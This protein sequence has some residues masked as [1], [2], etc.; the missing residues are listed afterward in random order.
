VLATH[1][2]AKGSEF[3]HVMVVMN[4][5]LAGGN[6]ISYDKMLGLC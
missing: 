1:Q 5:K 3:L 2:V 4:D 6:Q